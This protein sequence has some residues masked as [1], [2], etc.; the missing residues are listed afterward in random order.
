MASAAELAVGAS[1]YQGS[2][3]LGGGSFGAVKLDVRPIE[4]LAKYTFLYNKSEYDQRQK[5][6]EAAAAEIADYTSYDLTTGIPKDA[7]LLQEKYDKLTAY[8]RENPNA[9][10]YRNKK[11]WAEYK[12][13]RND[14][15]NDLKSAKVRN[16]MWDNRQKEVQDAKSPEEKQRLQKKLDEEIEATDIRTPLK[17]TDQYNIKP[18]EVSAAPIKKVQVTEIGKNIIGQD[19]LEMP[20]MDAVTNQ[21]IAIT[22]GLM[23]LE[24]FKKT[25]TYLSKSPEAQ[26]LYI[27]QYEAQSASGKLEPIESAKN[28]NTAIQGLPETYYKDDGNGSKVLDKEKLLE[29]DNGI[30][31]G[32]VQQ[33]EIYNRKMQE[34]KGWIEK[35]F[36]K[37]D[38]NN[39]LK[40][41]ND[42]SGLK[43]GSYKEIDIDDGLS[44]E[45]L[46][47]MKILGASAATSREIKIIETDDGIQQQ[48]IA[49]QIRGQNVAA[50]TQDKDRAESRRQFDKTHP[51]GGGDAG[52]SSTSGNAFD[53]IGGTTEI[54]VKTAGVFSKPVVISDGIVYNDKNGL[55]TGKLKIP[56]DQLPAGMV[57]ALKTAGTELPG[58]GEVEVTAKNGEIISVKADGKNVVTRQNMEN[59]QKKFD[60]EQKGQERTKWGRTLGS[61]VPATSNNKETPAERAK[62]IANE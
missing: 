45:E 35:G 46:V 38:F 36:F 43:K 20:D 23:S 57:G 8:V 22:S 50:S 61:P 12:K 33:V 5:D 27:D 16:T 10:D 62:R 32:I 40:F 4:D 28:F 15:E 60:T 21:S 7:K 6:V 55:F 19:I 37:D 53:E 17:F 3:E 11:E 41:N 29:S 34:M 58:D 30:I 39:Q 54:V 2:S 44:A 18:V 42:G 49:A 1:N 51:D 26:K 52:N 47:K 24:D 25:D 9:L 59:A 48:Q 31:R 14:L 56:A 13:M